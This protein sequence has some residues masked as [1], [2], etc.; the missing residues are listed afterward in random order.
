[1]KVRRRNNKKSLLKPASKPNAG[2]IKNVHL[3]ITCTD[4]LLIASILIN[5]I[6]LVK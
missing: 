5:G 4:N 2:C 1:M 6:M 3:E